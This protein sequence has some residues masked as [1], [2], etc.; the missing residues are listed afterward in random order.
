MTG[1]GATLEAG[2]NIIVLGKVVHNFTL[3]FITP[4]KP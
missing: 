3:A 1:I 4:L 2:Y